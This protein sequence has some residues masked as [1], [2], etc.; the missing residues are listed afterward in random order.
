MYPIDFHRYLDTNLA[1]LK[2]QTCEPFLK[3]TNI[4]CIYFVVLY[5]SEGKHSQTMMIT[6]KVSSQGNYIK[7][8]L[9]SSW[10]QARGTEDVL[11]WWP[12][13]KDR[14]CMEDHE[15][16]GQFTNPDWR[17]IAIFRTANMQSV[18]IFP[19]HCNAVAFFLVLCK[20]ICAQSWENQWSMWSMC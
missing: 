18:R 2:F 10:F 4:Y 11:L 15:F 14:Q 13:Q 16:D 19:L 20:Q 1:G 9:R 6:P 17:M 5:W 12:P 7:F 3:S 8:K